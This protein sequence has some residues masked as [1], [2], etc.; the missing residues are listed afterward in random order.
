MAA[1]VPALP[2][3]V[4]FLEDLTRLRQQR[5]RRMIGEHDA[6]RV[7]VVDRHPGVP[8]QI[9]ERR[10]R[11]DQRIEGQDELID[12]PIERVR[13]VVPPSGDTHAEILLD[14]FERRTQV[15]LLYPRTRRAL[16]VEPA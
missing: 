9:R 8:T 6:K 15:P 10:Q 7:L 12:T 16:R 3:I 5:L 13:I 14:A 11:R 4:A 1:G 2:A